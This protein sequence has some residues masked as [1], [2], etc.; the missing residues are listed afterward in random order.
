M[1]VLEKQS[2]LI[3]THSNICFPFIPPGLTNGSDEN[4]YYRYIAID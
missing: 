2:I 4:F 1:E 3:F